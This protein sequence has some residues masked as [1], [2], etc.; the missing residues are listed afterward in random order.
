MNCEDAHLFLIVRHA[1]PLVRSKH[2]LPRDIGHVAEYLPRHPRIGPDGLQK[3]NVD[4]GGSL[5][6]IGVVDIFQTRFARVA[7]RQAENVFLGN[8]DGGEGA[9]PRG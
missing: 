1:S 9:L 5:R 3:H 8:V 2:A 4:C 6:G 7:L